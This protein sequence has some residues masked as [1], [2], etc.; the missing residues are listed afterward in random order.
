[1]PTCCCKISHSLSSPHN[2]TA[3]VFS[4]CSLLITRKQLPSNSSKRLLQGIPQLKQETKGRKAAEMDYYFLLYK[5]SGRAG[6]GFSVE[7]QGWDPG[8]IV[9]ADISQ[10]CLPGSLWHIF[11]LACS[12]SLAC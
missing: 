10:P 11:M 4:V 7:T 9:V 1:M 6:V 3:A 12:S 2:S 8:L 5:V